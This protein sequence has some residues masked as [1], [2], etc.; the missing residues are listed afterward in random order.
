MNNQQDELGRF[1]RKQRQQITPDSVGISD[2]G[3]RRTPGLRREEVAALSGISVAWYTRL[4]QGRKVTPSQQVLE[5]VARTLQMSP[6]EREHLFRL[7]RRENP[8]DRIPDTET[9]PQ[10]LVD[11]VH[12]LDP[13]VALLLDAASNVLAHNRSAERYF[14]DD[15]HLARYR[16][17]LIGQLLSDPQMKHML[18]DDW[19]AIAADLIAQLRASHA[20]WPENQAIDETIRELTGDTLFDDCWRRPDVGEPAGNF[21]TYRSPGGEENRFQHMA[22]YPSDAQHLRL[23]VLK[24]DSG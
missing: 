13:A 6:V 8:P 1:L 21:V 7:A 10:Y 15:N 9:P 12:S 19:K 23:I 16:R 17:N 11:F 20:R 2:G 4:E 22:F 24:P 18:A 5:S 14:G 3:R